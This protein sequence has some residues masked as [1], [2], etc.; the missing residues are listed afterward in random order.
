MKYEPDSPEELPSL[1]QLH[2]FLL[3]VECGSIGRAA[4]E[5][6]LSQPA[7]SAAVARLEQVFGATLLVRHVS[8]SAASPTGELLAVRVRRF[9]ARL[10]Q[11]LSALELDWG[12]HFGTIL[13]LRMVHLRAHIAIS[14]FGTF[15]RGAKHLGISDPALHRAARELEK[16]LGRELYRIGTAGI[17]TNKFGE[18][19][20]RHMRLALQELLQAREEVGRRTSAAP[21]RI[22]AGILPLMPKRWAARVVA[23]TRTLYPD[24][25]I[26]LREGN[27]A[28]LLQELRWGAIDV[29]VGALPPAGEPDTIQEPLFADPYVLVV[30]R[31]HP[32]ANIRPLSRKMLT[33]HDWVVP[34]HNLPR[35]AALERFFATLP[36]RPRIWLDTS[37]PGTMMAVLAE[38]DC[39]TLIS[40][41]QLLMDGPADLAVLPIEVSDGGRMVG[42][43]KRRDWLPTPVQ[44]G[45]L[46]AL[47]EMPP[48]AEAGPP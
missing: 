33:K 6:G 39:I 25:L 38:T 31:G 45:F 42:I 7:A 32:L 2:C 37:S 5:I 19:L 35:R 27:H 23:R 17:G 28:V 14:E 10:E 43:T 24:A 20:A 47:T 9:F 3:A 44:R 1:R 26:E 16:L 34:S 41:T 40:H 8:G 11:G 4:E 15:T 12:I 21:A 29:I 36:T 13:K 22:S 46:Q 18:V 48:S 30:R